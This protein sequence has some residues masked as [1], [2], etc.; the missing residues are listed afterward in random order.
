MSRPRLN[1]TRSDHDGSVLVHIEGEIDLSTAP[2]FERE[3]ME[4]ANNG[5]PLI[6]DLCDV[7][8]MDSTGIGVLVRTSKKL[9]E[10]NAAMSLVCAKGP[11]RK[12]LEVSG[13]DG[14]IPLYPDLASVGQDA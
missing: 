14:V 5:A 6:V 13:L 4:S 7:E 9:T 1:V 10:Q 3:L 12:V 11:V 2:Q 8:F